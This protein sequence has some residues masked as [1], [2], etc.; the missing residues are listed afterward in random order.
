MMGVCASSGCAALG[1]IVAYRTNAV[2]LSILQG[3]PQPADS[4]VCGLVVSV[5]SIAHTRAKPGLSYRERGW[6]LADV[7][8][9]KFLLPHLATL[10]LLII[11]NLEA[12]GVEP[13]SS[14]R[15]TQTSTCLSDV[16]V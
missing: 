8:L 14:K 13:L 5:T 6:D 7:F 15:S 9:Y 2:G 10:R 1:T 11:N 4:P 3:P 12:R 16:E